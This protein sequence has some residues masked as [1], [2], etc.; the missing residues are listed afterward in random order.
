MDNYSLYIPRN[1]LNIKILYCNNSKNNVKLLQTKYGDQQKLNQE[2]GLDLYT[3][4]TITIPKNSK[5]FKI[6]LGISASMYMNYMNIGYMLLPRSSTGTKTPLRLSNSI[7]IIDSTY[8]GELIA[9]VDNISQNDDFTIEE[10]NRYFQI[11]AFNGFPIVPLLVDNLN[12]TARG[13]GGF[14]STG[15]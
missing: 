10:G 4:K 12:E 14:G 13:E 9:C 15:Y 11:V 8:R 6:P 2:S 1:C 5:G 7:G 3:P